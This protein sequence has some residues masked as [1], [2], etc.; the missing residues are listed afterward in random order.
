MR[1]ASSADGVLMTRV[2]AE[3]IGAMRLIQL[4]GLEIERLTGDYAKV[5]AEIEGYEK[6]LGDRNLVLGMIKDD[7]AEMKSRYATPR[8]TAIEESAT[9]IDIAR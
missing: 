6:I 2:Q 9:D 5:V 3:A 8:R 7:C 4:V 1:V